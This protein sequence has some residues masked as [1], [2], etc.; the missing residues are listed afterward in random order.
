WCYL[1]LFYAILCHIPCDIFCFSFY[2]NP[3]LQSPSI[4]SGEDEC[5]AM[6]FANNFPQLPHPSVIRLI[7]ITN[8]QPLEHQSLRYAEGGPS[9]TTLSSPSVDLV[10]QQAASDNGS[11]SATR[12]MTKVGRSTRG[13]TAVEQP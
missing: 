11:R 8:N 7:T 4:F 2:P 3:F 12:E 9:P 5:M 1:L 10:P 13:A 6:K